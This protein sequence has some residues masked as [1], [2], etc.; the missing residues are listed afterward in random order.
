MRDIKKEIEFVK[1][2]AENGSKPTRVHFLNPIFVAVFY[3]SAFIIFMSLL[4]F[5]AQIQHTSFSKSFIRSLIIFLPLISVFVTLYLLSNLLKFSFSQKAASTTK[6]AFIAV[7]SG[8]FLLCVSSFFCDQLIWRSKTNLGELL[9]AVKEFG[10]E[11]DFIQ[12]GYKATDISGDYSII[13]ILALAWWLCG[14]ILNARTMSMLGLLGFV[15]APFFAFFSVDLNHFFVNFLS[16]LVFYLVL[17]A[18]YFAFSK[19]YSLND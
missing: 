13:L 1:A 7:W 3:V 11:R 8:I 14:T 9:I 2:M 17:P 6:R 5:D 19:K 10:L 4:Y 12:V 18:T 15:V 16:I